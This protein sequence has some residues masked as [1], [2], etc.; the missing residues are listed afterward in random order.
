M[1]RKVRLR[2]HCDR[3]SDLMILLALP[4]LLVAG[5]GYL[6]WGQDEVAASALP[7]PLASSAGMRQYYLSTSNYT[8]GNADGTDACAGGYHFAS[9]WEILDP[10]NLKYNTALGYVRADS[11]QGPPSYIEGWIR[12]GSTSSDDSTPGLG[13]CSAWGSSDGAQYGT[14]VR[15]PDDWDAATDIHAWDASTYSCAFPIRVWCVADDA[16]SPVYLPL[17]V[18]NI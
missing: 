10:A 2:I 15:L 3:R 1:N 11:G 14:T 13:N 7:A 12:T 5:L 18:R 9:L 16:G 8:G 17:V 6:A 4:L